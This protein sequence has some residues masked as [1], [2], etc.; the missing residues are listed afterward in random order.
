MPLNGH[1]KAHR[2]IRST[3]LPSTRPI[4]FG[5][6]AVLEWAIGKGQEQKY[7]EAG[8]RR[9]PPAQ[10]AFQLHGH[11]LAHGLEFRVLFEQRQFN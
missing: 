10:R 6:Q 3:N 8:Q 5:Q 4:E 7:D 9:Q 1:G 2:P 11:P